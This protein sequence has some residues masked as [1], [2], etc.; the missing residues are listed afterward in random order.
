MSGRW[1]HLDVFTDR[2]FEGNPL[3]VFPEADDIVP[4]SMQRLAAEIGFSETTFVLEP[5]PGTDHRVRIFTP[6]RELPMAGHPTIGTT[7][8]LAFE[9][10]IDPGVVRI[11]LGLG[12]GPTPVD[13][14][15]SGDQLTFA[16][17]TQPLPVF[18]PTVEAIDGLAATLGVNPSAIGATSLPVQEVSCGVPFLFVPLA[19]RDDVDRAVSDAAAEHAFFERTGIAPLPIFLFSVEKAPDGATAYSRMFAPTFGIAEDPA[20]G[21]ASGP[22]GAYL[23]QHRVVDPG[24]A[25]SMLSLQGVAMGRP[26]RI[27]IAITG[28]PGAI[29]D[30]KVGG[31]AVLVADGTFFL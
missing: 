12:V 11:V 13:L 28:E 7:F 31:Q 16:W 30:V 8:A 18:G 5:E 27:H 2:P 9:H 4:A 29:T 22:L 23:I 17:M 21:G 20:T 24:S 25:A 19:T 26:S 1:L 14:R 3:G 15:W 10:D 6:A